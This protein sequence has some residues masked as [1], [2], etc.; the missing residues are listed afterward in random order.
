M[1]Y[2]LFYDAVPDYEARRIPF[3]SEHLRH[4]WRAV[5]RGELIVAGALADPVDAAVFLFSGTSPAPAEDFARKD[6]Y[7]LNGLVKAWRV[8][9]WTTVVGPLAAQPIH[10]RNLD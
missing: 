6:P 2:L 9:P 8:R 5:E 10:P 4:A 1:H 3:R 7:V